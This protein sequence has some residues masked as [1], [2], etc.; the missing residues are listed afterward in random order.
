[1]SAIADGFSWTARKRSQK[2]V[3]KR[4]RTESLSTIADGFKKTALFLALHH[5]LS[6]RL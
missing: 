6:D 1:M 5:R 2:T 3:V 4:I